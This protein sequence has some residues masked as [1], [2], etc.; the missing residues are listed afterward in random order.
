MHETSLIDYALNAVEARA[1]QMGIQEVAEV[2]LVVGKAKAIPE[3]LERAFQIIR[4]KHPR[5]REAVLHLDMRE[6]RMQC[7]SCGMEYE[8]EALMGDDRCPGC[9]SCDCRM[10][11]GNELL[12]EYFIPRE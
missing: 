1:S 11:G 10:V 8:V 9:G 6:I 5:C 3:L 12:V 4:V 2:G 7:S